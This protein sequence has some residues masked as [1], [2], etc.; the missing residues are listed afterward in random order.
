MCARGAGPST[1]SLDQQRE[2]PPLS[3][4][5]GRIATPPFTPVLSES[6]QVNHRHAASERRRNRTCTPAFTPVL[7][8]SDGAR[9]VD[10]EL[11][12]GM[13]RSVRRV[14]RDSPDFIA[15][16]AED[17][18]EDSHE[19]K[20]V[21]NIESIIH[22]EAMRRSADDE[23]SSDDDESEADFDVEDD[24]E[25]HGPQSS[26]NSDGDGDKES[27]VGKK[28]KGKAAGRKKKSEAQRK[29]EHNELV[30]T[31]FAGFRC[32]CARAKTSG[33]ESCLEAISKQDLRA[34]HRETYGD[35]KAIQ[36]AQVLH[37]IHS[38]YWA[39]SV[40]LPTPKG[41][42]SLKS[43]HEGRTRKL[44][45]PL[46]LLGKYPVCSRA[47]EMAVGGS[48]FAH[49]SKIHLVTRGFGPQSLK[50]A[51]LA[52]LELR[53][54]EERKGVKT[55]RAAWARTWWADEL[56]LHDWLP[57]ETAIQFKGVPWDLLHR[58]HYTAAAVANSGDRPL[59][60][61]A[62]KAQMLPGARLLA[63]AQDPPPEDCTKIR[64]RR[65][66]R[67]S[68]FPE[69]NDCKRLRQAYM[70]VM[71]TAGS[72][73]ARRDTALKA[74]KAHMYDWQKDRAVSL[75]RD[76]LKKLGRARNIAF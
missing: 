41:A 63:E 68:N 48:R 18:H 3:R 57:N 47:F 60:Y 50:S 62:W 12:M 52:K 13:M 75:H 69:C 17:G 5:S 65:S 27:G 38:L 40:P 66:A 64:V 56:A 45:S 32:Q 55:R 49:R 11:D 67:H 70:D 72:S 46:R 74:L 9:F 25:Y 19:H 71:T 35:G 31:C 15:L 30:D 24:E 8:P 51:Q 4:A 76:R 29:E 7:G 39:L 16:R 2:I 34:I 20:E 61:K 36:P 23:D 26:D 42:P 44:P 58:E 43:A 54:L 14:K 53:A 6:H 37:N 59:K 22:A 10:A 73:Q 21:I 33:N 1:S 28:S